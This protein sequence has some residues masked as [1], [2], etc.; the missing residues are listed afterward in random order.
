[1]GFLSTPEF[2]VAVSF[3][4]FVA[5][6]VYFKVPAMVA[7]A[8]DGRAERIRAELDEA[9][10]LREEAQ[11][12]LAEY[13]RKRRDAEKEAE[14]IITLAREEAERLSKE[15][16]AAL[17]ETVERRLLATEAKIAQAETQAIDE[18]RQAAAD[19]AL[20]AAETVISKTMSPERRAELIASGIEEVKAKLN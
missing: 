13:Q 5:V 2:W 6:L 16:R 9:Q 17:E 14:D 11:G 1:M 3:V 4:G 18:V 10:R 12:L 19:A 20:R 7:K 15:T 8:L